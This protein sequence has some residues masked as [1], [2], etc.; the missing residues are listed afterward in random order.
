VTSVLVDFRKWPDTVHWQFTMERLGVDDYGT[1]LW[2]PAGTVA[3]RGDAA[4]IRFGHLAVKVVPSN[5]WW[6]AIFN[7]AAANRAYVDIITP[8]SWSSD[9]VTMIDLDLDVVVAADGAVSIEDEDEF[10]HHQLVLGYPEHVIARARATT[11]EIVLAIERGDEPF[12]SV[13]SQWIDE[14]KTIAADE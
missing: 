14:A 6:T 1:W 12:A 5:Q 9:R 4:P 13:A 11:A 7:D 2:A 10:L 3:Q 8:P